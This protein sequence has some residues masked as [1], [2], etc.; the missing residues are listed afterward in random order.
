MPPDSFRPVTIPITVEKRTSSLTSLLATDVSW[1]SPSSR[2]DE[3]RR[4]QYGQYGDETGVTYP[5]IGE[6]VLDMAAVM[7]SGKRRVTPETNSSNTVNNRNRMNNSNYMSHA[8]YTKQKRDQIRRLS[9]ISHALGEHSLEEC[10]DEDEGDDDVEDDDASCDVEGKEE[11]INMIDS[12]YNDSSF[13]DRGMG[14]ASKDGKGK[15]EI[16]GRGGRE[17]RG[18]GYFPED[19]EEIQAQE[20]M[21][22]S[23]LEAQNRHM[24]IRK[25]SATYQGALHRTFPENSR[26][27]RSAKDLSSTF[28]SADYVSHTTSEDRNMI[29]EGRDERDG[30]DDIAIIRNQRSKIHGKKE[31]PLVSAMRNRAVSSTE[32]A[33][34]RWPSILSVCLFSI[35]FRFIF[36]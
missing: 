33:V 24:A 7:S 3:K 14:G 19:A 17:G 13:E 22:E 6:R 29:N 30:R 23:I 28:L 36:D 27:E 15:S 9:G 26:I 34:A 5:G 21:F 35:Y 18:E 32:T 11:R 10:N 2:N 4:Q 1:S 25:K 31:P 12:E 8:E 20:A 16:V